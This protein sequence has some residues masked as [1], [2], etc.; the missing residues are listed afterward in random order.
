MSRPSPS[1]PRTRESIFVFTTEVPARISIRDRTSLRHPWT[2]ASAGVTDRAFPCTPL[3]SKSGGQAPALQRKAP[4]C[5]S[6][7]ESSPSVGA[8]NASSILPHASWTPASA[9]V[10]EWEVWFQL[11]RSSFDRPVLSLSK[12]SGR[13]ALVHSHSKA[14]ISRAFTA[15]QRVGARLI[16]PLRA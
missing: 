11:D 12:C 14:S 4:Y 16:V 5:G 10:T 8:P 1:L 13:T 2:P 9:G 15:I 6:S 3:A 7:R